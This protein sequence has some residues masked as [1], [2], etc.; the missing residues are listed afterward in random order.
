MTCIHVIRGEGVK[1]RDIPGTSFLLTIN[2]P[3]TSLEHQKT[4]SK[5]RS[6]DVLQTYLR[7]KVVAYL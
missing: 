4:R 5:R 1:T 7:K 6:G 3:R 2:I